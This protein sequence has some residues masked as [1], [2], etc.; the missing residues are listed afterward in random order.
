MKKTIIWFDIDAGIVGGLMQPLKK[1][2]YQVKSFKSQKEIRR[3]INRRKDF[4]DCA[5]IVMDGLHFGNY[6]EIIGNIRT[7]AGC[8]APVVFLTLT[9]AYEF[10]DKILESLG[11]KKVMNKLDTFPSDLSKEVMT[12][13][14]EFQKLHDALKERN[15]IV[16]LSEGERGEIKFH[17]SIPDSSEVYPA[18]GNPDTRSVY[19]KIAKIC[20]INGIK[21]FC[22]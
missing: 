22:S 8:D 3:A 1:Q 14:G 16:I 12:L 10:D 21:K 18:E 6:D 7:E 17:A 15:K 13:L 2:G 20:S 9:K 4:E 11:V 5:I 19:L